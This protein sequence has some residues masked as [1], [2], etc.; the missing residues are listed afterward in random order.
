MAQRRPWEVEDGLWEL[1]ESLLPQVERRFR[2]RPR[3][4]TVK[5]FGDCAYD[6]DKY[7][8]LVQAEGIRPSSPAAA[9]RTARGWA[10]TGTWRS[11]PS[12]CCTGSGGC[13]S[14]GRSA[15]TSTRHS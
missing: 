1:I 15:T 7:R 4:R 9:S 12:R 5:V 3:R 13:G 10:S 14:A 6:H 2:G 11:R 8:A